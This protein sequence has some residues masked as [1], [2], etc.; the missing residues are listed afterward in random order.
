MID[1]A[2]LVTKASAEE[3]EKPQVV[4]AVV[5]WKDRGFGDALYFSRAN[6]PFGTGEK[7][8]LVSMVGTGPHYRVF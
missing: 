3:A 6:I 4:K 8:L 5:S 2:T 1:L 7:Y